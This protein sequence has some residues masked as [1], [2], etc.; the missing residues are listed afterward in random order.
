MFFGSPLFLYGQILR[1][2]LLL[3]PQV[4]EEEDPVDEHAEERF[5][6]L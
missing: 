6:S 3:P 4:E 2:M 1:P 5:G